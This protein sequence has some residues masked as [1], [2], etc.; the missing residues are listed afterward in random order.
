MSK[1]QAVILAG[2]L[3]SRLRPYT[4]VLP[5]PLVPVH[6]MPIA[7]IIVRQLKSYGFTKV[8]M[9]TGYLSGL[10]KAYFGDGTRWGVRIEY[11][12]EKKPLGT[13]GAINLIPDVAPHF[14]VV[15][16]DT[17]TD[18]D[19]RGLTA[20]HKRHEGQVTMVLKERIVRTD[21]GVVESDGKGRFLDYIEK[22]EH[23]S[24]V[25]T[26]INMFSRRCRRYIKR[27]ERIGMPELMLRLRD[28]GEAVHCYPMKGLWLDLGRA[29]DLERSQEMF[30]RHGRKFL[31]D[32]P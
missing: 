18:L 26:G 32:K 7:E 17:L 2:G 21:F 6:G 4:A 22:P 10:I 9:A 14:L 28:A 1:I 11:V 20:F 8:C 30:R 27:N 31:K 15:N 25:S 16:G 23:R 5:K 3:G 13:A 12:E 29:D 24:F 19:F